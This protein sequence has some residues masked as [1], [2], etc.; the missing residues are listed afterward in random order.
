MSLEAGLAPD[1]PV[2]TLSYGVIALR[3]YGHDVQRFERALEQAYE[4]VVE[5]GASPYKLALLA[6][7]AGGGNGST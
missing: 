3:R 7:A 4:R 2:M 5:R 1:T 6:L